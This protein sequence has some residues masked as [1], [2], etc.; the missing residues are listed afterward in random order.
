MWRCEGHVERCLA[1]IL[2]DYST[3]FRF[4]HIESSIVQNLIHF[5][6]KSDIEAKQ[7]LMQLKENDRYAEDVWT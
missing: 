4:V 3:T 5:E 2:D 1:D 6:G 7:L